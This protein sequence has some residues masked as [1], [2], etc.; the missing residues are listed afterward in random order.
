MNIF[1]ALIFIGPLVMVAE[2]SANLKNAELAYHNKNLPNKNEVVA[3]ELIKG[4]Y[5]LSAAHFAVKHVEEA[6]EISPEFEKSLEDIILK[7]GTSIFLGLDARTLSKHKSPSLSFILGIKLFRDKNYKGTYQILKNIGEQNRFYPEAKY[8][9]ASALNL[10]NEQG[11]ATS[12]YNQ[13]IKSS[14]SFLSKSEHKKLKRY[15]TILQENCQIH[16]ARMLYR[17]KDYKGAIEAY[18]QIAKTSYLWPYI[19]LEKAWSYYYLEDYNRALGIN[20]T[21]RSPLLSSYFFPESEVLTALS[22]YRL[23][24]WD[25]SLKVIDQY[26]QVYK[27]RSD[28][29]KKLLLTHKDSHTYFIELVFSPVE[30]SENLNPYIRNLVTQIRKK[31][32]FSV[33]LVALKRAQEEYKFL[34][35]LQKTPFTEEILSSVQY[36]V[37]WQQRYLNHYVKKNMFQFINDIHKY[38]YEMFNVRLEIL[39]DKRDLVYNNQKLVSDR[40]RGS[41]S[42]VKRSLEQH[43]YNFTGEFWADEL[44]D[45][46]FGLQ[47]NCG[48]VSINKSK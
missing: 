48:T 21:Y 14:D 1:K 15:Y 35:S 18:E 22:Y 46:S 34:Q 17:S 43:F 25:D 26:Y 29:L 7:T 37:G 36:S 9:S 44:G 11:A 5:Y 20:V 13:C 39:S 8:I 30:K 16:N 33:D 24:L 42:N 6:N 23:C 45:Y 10:L 47:S 31:I 41:A 4:N 19:L 3:T 32:K 40:S 2:T 27:S 38:S 28:E 12:D